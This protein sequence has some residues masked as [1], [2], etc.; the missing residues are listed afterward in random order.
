MTFQKVN[1]Q[2]ATTMALLSA[3]R[4]LLKCTHIVTGLYIISLDWLMHSL[5]NRILDMLLVEME[6]ILNH[7]IYK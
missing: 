2:S 7:V 5:T 6:H 4:S 1:N 3:L